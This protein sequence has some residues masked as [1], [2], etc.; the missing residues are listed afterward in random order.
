MAHFGRFWVKEPRHSENEKKKDKNCYL[1]RIT[2]L[3]QRLHER[4]KR[5]LVAK[6]FKNQKNGIIKCSENFLVVKEPRVFSEKRSSQKV[7]ATTHARSQHA[8][9]PCPQ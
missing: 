4:A 2:R 7:S 6:K 5:V 8:R 3:V 1:H 9:Q